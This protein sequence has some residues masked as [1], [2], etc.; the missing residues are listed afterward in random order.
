M[1]FPVPIV[2]PI[3]PVPILL[4]RL[5]IRDPLNPNTKNLELSS[6][7]AVY[8]IRVSLSDLQP[9]NCRTQR[10]IGQLACRP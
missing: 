3:I 6:I 9:I 2:I 5:E 1:T 10:D 4:A 8:S 7:L